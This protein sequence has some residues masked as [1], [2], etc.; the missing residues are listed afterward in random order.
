MEII[1]P[2]KKLSVLL[3]LLLEY[4]SSTNYPLLIWKTN[5]LA[6]YGMPVSVAMSANRN[7]IYVSGYDTGPLF[8]TPCPGNSALSICVY[9]MKFDAYT[10]TLIWINWW[11]NLKGLEWIGG[12]D[13][14]P[15]TDIP[16]V[17]GYTSDNLD[18]QSNQDQ[19]KKSN[20]L[21]LLSFNKNTGSRSTNLFGSPADDVSGN[22]KI[23]QSSNIFWCGWTQG[24]ILG[25]MNLG[26]YD[27]FLLKLFSNSTIQWARQW[28][29][30]QDDFGILLEFSNDYSSIWVA[31]VWN[32]GTRVGPFTWWT[33]I[34]QGTKIFLSSKTITKF[35]QKGI[36]LRKDVWGDT[37]GTLTISGLNRHKDGNLLITLMTDTP[38]DQMQNNGFDDIYVVSYSTSEYTARTTN[39]VCGTSLVEY[40]QGSAIDSASNTFYIMGHTYVYGQNSY[41][42]L[43]GYILRAFDLSTESEV[44]LDSGTKQ[45][46]GISPLSFG[47]PVI[48]QKRRKLYVV[49]SMPSTGIFVA[50]YGLG[51][52]NKQNSGT[53]SVQTTTR[54]DETEI[55]LVDLTRVERVSV[56]SVVVVGGIV[57]VLLLLSVVIFL[58]F[59]YKKSKRA[60][61]VKTRPETELPKTLPEEKANPNNEVSPQNQTVFDTSGGTMFEVHTQ[62]DQDPQG[63]TVN[64]TMTFA[65]TKLA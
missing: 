50:A 17:V 38:F 60:S 48:D 32:Q 61:P 54:Q 18:G 64:D 23:D 7:Y 14:D 22:M 29:T 16:Y 58:L 43:K 31:G 9:L 52:V 36:Q 4:V 51:P 47:L 59:K 63:K 44:F 40:A 42:S 37:N 13:V 2:W 15:I 55:P 25:Q 26:G 12:L 45:I 19:T 46:G 8:K 20:D 6:T 65:E 30:I 3:F 1:I 35:D 10:G 33:P 5:I 24:Q 41:F 57:G 39:I 21:Y 49:G 56:I 28:G 11:G 62:L 27:N 53:N 34:V